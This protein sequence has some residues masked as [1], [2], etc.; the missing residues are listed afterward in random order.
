MSPPTS[1]VKKKFHTERPQRVNPQEQG[2]SWKRGEKQPV[3]HGYK[4]R[5]LQSSVENYKSQAAKYLL[6]QHI[7]SHKAHHIYNDQGKRLSIDILLSGEHGD[8]R[9][10]PALSNEWGRLAQG[11]YAGVEATDTI[12]SFPHTEVP[13]RKR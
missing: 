9:W 6:A 12:E 8:S 13:K 4:L 10:M 1:R 3:N 11:N 5:S 7:F 2:L